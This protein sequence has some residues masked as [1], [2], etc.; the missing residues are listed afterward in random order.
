MAD[1]IDFEN[2]RISNFQ[3]HVTLTLTLDR[4]IVL[5]NPESAVSSVLYSTVTLTFDLLIPNC[6]A[7]IS[8]P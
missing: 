4:D 1:E 7:F 8:V 2:R 5:T 6:Q 3:C